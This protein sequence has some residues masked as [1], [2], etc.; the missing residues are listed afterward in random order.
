MSL[1]VSSGYDMGPP[2]RSNLLRWI[3]EYILEILDFLIKRTA[4]SFSTSSFP[5]IFFPA[6]LDW[7]FPSF[8]SILSKGGFTILVHN[9]LWILPSHLLLREKCRTTS[10]TLSEVTPQ[11][12]D[13]TR[14]MR[15]FRRVSLSNGGIPLDKVT[16]CSTPRK[17]LPHSKMKLI[18]DV[19]MNSL[20]H[21]GLRFGF[22]IC[23]G[24]FVLSF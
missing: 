24:R 20:S 11:M 19:E 3:S 12:M 14:V 5:Q 22:V 17:T 1:E 7:H 4:T 8:E 10:L 23:S 6:K 15:P 2:K 9:V 21:R 13:D 16:G 18:A